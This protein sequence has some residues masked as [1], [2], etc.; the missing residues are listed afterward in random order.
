M[1]E[2]YIVSSPIGVFGIN[3]K[4]EIKDKALFSK[5][6]EATATVL[7]A[8]QRGEVIRQVEDVVSG[9]KAKGVR[10]FI[11]EDSRLG[12]SVRSLLEVE[13]KVTKGGTLVSEFRA[14]LSEIA[15]E[16]SFV[17]TS[18]AYNSW[19]R[20]VTASIVRVQV[21]LSSARRDLQVVQGVLTLD[22][23]DKS[24]NLY[25]GRVREWDGL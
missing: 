7:R 16:L 12:N 15:V 24:L 18:T 4:G 6:V 11:F 10:T 21:K 1:S 8:L 19:V 25:A 3:G 9:L 22:D 20:D 2:V 13:V 5:D 14:R 23:L 17:E